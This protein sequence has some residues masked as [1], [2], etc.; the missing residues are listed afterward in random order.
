MA[1]LDL[2]ARLGAM[3]AVLALAA[4]GPAIAQENLDKGKSAAQLYASD[5][6]IC[7]KAPQAFVKGKRLVGLD[8]FLREHYTASRESA[9][10]IGA[11]LRSIGRGRSAAKGEDARKRKANAARAALPPRRPGE[12]KTSGSKASVSQPSASKPDKTN[13]KAAAPEQATAKAEA[14]KKKPAE[15]KPADSKS[16]VPQAT[17]EKPAPDAMPEKSD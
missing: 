6:A 13:T 12:P 1:M 7:H 5:C 8:G 15:P 3:A 17:P 11:Y 9:A 10:S 16:T 2:L 14:S 4:V